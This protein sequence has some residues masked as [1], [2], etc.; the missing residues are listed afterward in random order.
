MRAAGSEAVGGPMP[1]AFS[2]RARAGASRAGGTTRATGWA[3]GWC[4]DGGGSARGR[5]EGGLALYGS[6][7]D[8]PGF[9]SVS[10]LQRRPLTGAMD[11]TDGGY[12]LSRHRPRTVHHDVRRDRR[13]RP[14]DGS[15]GSTPASS[16]P[17]P[18]T[19]QLNQSDE[20]DRRTAFGGRFQVS[21]PSVAGDFSAG[22]DGRVDFAAYDLYRTERA[23]PAAPDQGVRRPLPGRRR[24]RPVAHAGGPHL[25]LDLGA[26][27]TA[28]TTGASTVWRARPGGAR[29]ELHR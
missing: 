16:S 8:S 21:R 15:S 3:T 10:R 26:R 14:L 22:F 17:S 5:L 6:N 20:E 23:S 19:T 1:A 4:G 2:W 29:D 11:P 13:S 12:R 25:A 18:R 24:V 28:S 27:P 9:V 7:W